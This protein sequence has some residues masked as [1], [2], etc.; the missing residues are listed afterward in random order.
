[1]FQAV[2]RHDG[3]TRNLLRRRVDVLLA[4]GPNDA[5][6]PTITVVAMVTFLLLVL[7]WIV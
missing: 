2:G 7:P 4:G 3:S 5:A 1:M 6:V